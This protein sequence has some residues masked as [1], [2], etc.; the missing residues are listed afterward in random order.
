MNAPN[1]ASQHDHGCSYTT[2]Y[3]RRGSD[4]GLR[5]RRPSHSRGANRLVMV[6]TVRRRRAKRFQ[7]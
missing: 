3:S 6:N 5:A 7:W 4:R 1:Y 2:D